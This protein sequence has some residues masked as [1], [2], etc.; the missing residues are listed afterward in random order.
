[1][2]I[3]VPSFINLLIFI[4]TS[5]SDMKITV[6]SDIAKY[7]PE[8]NFHSI[9][10][11]LEI[12]GDRIILFPESIK[13]DSITDENE[14]RVNDKFGLTFVPTEYFM[15]STCSKQ[16]I[17]FRL[18]TPDKYSVFPSDTY[19]IYY[20]FTY[21]NYFIKKTYQDILE[22]KLEAKPEKAPNIPDL[23]TWGS[24]PLP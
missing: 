8:Y 19:K 12:L 16:E 3:I 4:A 17:E 1:M 22:L 20:H 2:I 24:M 15:N 18:I 13:V 6:S 10:G 14:K 23:P 21:K 5:W 9:P 11:K 7:N